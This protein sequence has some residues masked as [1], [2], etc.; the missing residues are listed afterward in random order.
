[1]ILFNLYLFAPD[2]GLLGWKVIGLPVLY[3]GIEIEGYYMSVISFYW[4]VM[5][6]S[7]RSELPGLIFI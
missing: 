4:G 7:Y 3:A 2:I 1:M 5:P 6:V